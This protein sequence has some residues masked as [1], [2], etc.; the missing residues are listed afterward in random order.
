MP[1][2]IDGH[3]LIPKIPGMD[4]GDVDDETQLIE[5]LQEFCRR[6]RKQVEVYFDNAPAGQPRARKLGLVTARFARAGQ[7]ADALIHAHLQRLGRSA[8][9]WTVVSSDHQVQAAARAARAKFVT[10]EAFARELGVALAAPEGSGEVPGESEMET[11]I[12]SEELDE[13]LNLFGGD[14]GKKE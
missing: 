12:S 4:L 3:N 13:W 14:K 1:Y 6:R 7:S 5:K 8:R 9:N 10:S 11:G 2:L